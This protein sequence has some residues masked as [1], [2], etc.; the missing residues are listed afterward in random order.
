MKASLKDGLTKKLLR[1]ELLP[2]VNTT[3]LTGGRPLTVSSMETYQT[4]YRGLIFFF[5]LIGDFTSLLIL[6][7]T[8]PTPFCP[9]INPSS[10]VLFIKW[11]RQPVTTILKD[12]HENDVLDIYGMISQ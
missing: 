11:K 7:K 10:L 4:I 3:K 1:L 2:A 6:Q 9:S 12:I 8:S 5:T